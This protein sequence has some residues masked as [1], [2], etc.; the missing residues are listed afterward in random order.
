MY[1]EAEKKPNV[2]SYENKLSSEEKD[3]KEM[4]TNLEDGLRGV[5]L[6]RSRIGDNTHMAL[7]HGQHVLYC[8]SPNHKLTGEILLKKRHFSHMLSRRHWKWRARLLSLSDFW[9]HLG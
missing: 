8:T 9:N 6:H 7:A 4:Q 3:S 5:K 2:S 1:W